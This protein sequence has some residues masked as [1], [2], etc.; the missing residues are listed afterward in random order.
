MDT[1]RKTHSKRGTEIQIGL[2][3][4]ALNGQKSMDR[5]D[6]TYAMHVETPVHQRKITRKFLRTLAAHKKWPLGLRFRVV[7]EFFIQMK[8]STKQKYRYCKDRQ[9]S[10]LKNLGKSDCSQ[11]L[12]LDKKI[13]ISDDKSTTLRYII[14]SIKDVIDNRRIFATVDEK[15]NSDDLHVLSFRPD[16]ATKANGFVDS[17]STYVIHTFPNVSFEGILTIDSLEQAKYEKFDPSTQTFTT[18]DDIDLDMEIQADLDDDSFEYLNDDTIANPYEFEGTE[19]LVGSPKMWN[20]SGE[21]D[22]VSAMTASSVSF[23]NESTCMVFDSDA[24]AKRPESVPT[25]TTTIASTITSDMSHPIP[26][27]H[28][29][30]QTSTPHASERIN[31]LE[32]QLKLVQSQLALARAASSGTSPKKDAV[33]DK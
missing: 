1:Y 32:H 19:K 10:F 9:S 21:D 24:P 4:R 2:V 27:N 7:D 11:I 31:D 8:D 30:T 16:K 17:L 6:K 14:L 25:D 3:W 13:K 29:T 26:E 15:Y 23:T 5:K 22:T 20:L 28:P 12:N 18:E 33:E